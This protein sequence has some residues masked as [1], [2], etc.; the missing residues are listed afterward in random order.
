MAVAAFTR[1]ARGAPTHSSAA[2]A[3]HVSGSTAFSGAGASS[4]HTSQFSQHLNTSTFNQNLTNHTPTFTNP[5]HVTVPTNKL[6]VSTPTLNKVQVNPHATTFNTQVKTFD[7]H[8]SAFNSHLNTSV[9]GNQFQTFH[10]TPGAPFQ[11]HAISGNQLLLH[12]N[13][14]QVH[15]LNAH[16][17]HQAYLGNQAIHLAP[18]GYHP[19][20][21]MHSSW[22]HSPWSGSA[23]GWGWG[24]GPGFGFGF[25]GLG[26]GVGIGTG[27]GYGGFGYNPYRFYGP[28]G[29]W[30]RP[31]GWGFGGWGLGTL[32]YNSGY[33]PYY[34]P[35][36]Y[37]PA[38]Q[39]VVYNYSNPI[40]VATN[41]AA[42][43]NATAPDNSDDTPPIPQVENADF[44]AARAAFRD[45]RLP[46]GIGRRR[47]RH[48]A[49]AHRLGAA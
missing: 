4:T 44:D 31:L 26:W 16:M 8:V 40:P 29:Y 45:G 9:S 27:W 36:Y 47:C 21:L 24:L 15:A 5:A 34:N 2:A 3:P 25:G 28:Y 7:P 14:G 46:R 19:S 43:T 38:T 42:Y 49:N 18:M 23:W 17:Y 6:A 33:Y 20:Y 1:G 11:A 32:A 37:P 41:P 13:Q 12:T 48:L 10:K 35:Y 30:G 22:Y 39:T